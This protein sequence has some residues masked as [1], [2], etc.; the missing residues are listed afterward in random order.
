MAFISNCPKCQKSVLVPEGHGHDAVV[1]CPACFAEY[2]L[3]EILSAVPALIVVRPSTSAAVATNGDSGIFS[4]ARI[5]PDAVGAAASGEGGIFA[6]GA[7]PV[8]HDPAPHDSGALDFVSEGVPL[9]ADEGHSPTFVSDSEQAAADAL[10]LAAVGA[11]APA[12]QP[13]VEQA[14]EP[15][16]LSADDV[17]HEAVAEGGDRDNDWGGNWGGFGDN[18]AHAAGDDIAV[19]VAEHEGGAEDEMTHVD[20]AAL[21]GAAAPD[22][23]AESGVAIAVEPPKKK[24]RKRE[25]NPIIR[26]LGMAVAGLLAV[27]CV[28]AFMWWRGM[29]LDFL[30]SWLQFGKPTSQ[31]A[32]TKPATPPGTP[33]KTEPA[34][35][36]NPGGTETA[37]TGSEAGGNG[38]Q[39][40]ANIA[41]SSAGMP[42]T[43]KNEIASNGKPG[44]KSVPLETDESPEPGDGFGTGADDTQPPIAQPGRE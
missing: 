4:E 10:F 21:T 29:P 32:N 38:A 34:T 41:R 3:G 20:Y 40:A 31:S 27:A 23:A 44:K 16:M 39:P 42:A 28:F 26:L 19:G 11:D 6:H 7:H 8:L 37:K 2:S 18:A 1:Q 5:E 13:G 14:D 25:A 22:T 43:E 9:A 24:K 36:P 17:G 15:M 33:N 30:P 12:H 35:N